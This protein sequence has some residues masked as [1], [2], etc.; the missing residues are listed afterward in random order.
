MLLVIL[1]LRQPLPL[2][3]HLAVPRVL[4]PILLLLQLLVLPVTPFSLGALGAL[5]PGQL[6]VV[7][8]PK[9]HQEGLASPGPQ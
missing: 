3:G 8:L 2:H 5:H 7:L 4:L 1:V 6:V 9:C